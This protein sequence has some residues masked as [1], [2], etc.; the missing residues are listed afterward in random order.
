MI[1]PKKNDRSEM[2]PS[3]I[4][5]KIRNMLYAKGLTIVMCSIR[6][7]VPRNVMSD[8]LSGKKPIKYE[9]WQSI[10]NF[11]DLNYDTGEP[12]SE[13]VKKIRNRDFV[14]PINKKN[15]QMLRNM[16]GCIFVNKSKE[17]Y[18]VHEVAMETLT[19]TIYIICQKYVTWKNI[20][21]PD[22]E[23]EVIAI[24]YQRWCE[25][26]FRFSRDTDVI[27]GMDNT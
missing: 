16:L 12:I 15:Y 6:C 1:F 25:A 5:L 27:Q 26:G 17:Q 19:Q 18:I 22:I 7:S 11:F 20:N 9:H 13:K 8:C 23:Q 24:P 10:C 21:T 14:V 2:I 4:G 3:D